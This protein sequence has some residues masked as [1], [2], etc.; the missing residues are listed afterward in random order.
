MG[1]ELTLKKDKGVII[2]KNPDNKVHGS[3]MGPIWGRKDPG[4]PH[5]GPMNF[6]IWE[7][8]TVICVTSSARLNTQG[9]LLLTRLN[10]NH[11]MHK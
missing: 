4:G 2:N 11:S 5:V 8:I 1:F 7:Q 10:F 9:P 6:A 3:N